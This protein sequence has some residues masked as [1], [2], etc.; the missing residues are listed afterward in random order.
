M[1]EKQFMFYLPFNINLLTAFKYENCTNIFSIIAV[2]NAFKII[3][4]LLNYELINN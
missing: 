4:F 3:A 1:L 2:I